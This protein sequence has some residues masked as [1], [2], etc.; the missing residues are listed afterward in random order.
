MSDLKTV[1]TGDDLPLSGGNAKSLKQLLDTVNTSITYS[2]DN[3]QVSLAVNKWA[4]SEYYCYEDFW[5]LQMQVDYFSNIVNY[6]FE[7]NKLNR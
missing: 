7:D 6:H 2:L 3:K 1:L 4:A 5:L